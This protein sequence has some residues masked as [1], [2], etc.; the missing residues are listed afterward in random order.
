MIFLNFGRYASK[1]SKICF[2]FTELGDQDASAGL[3]DN[4]KKLTLQGYRVALDGYGNGSLN[5]RRISELSVNT[6]RLD[7]SLID[8]MELPGGE[9]V[10]RGMIGM[11]QSIPLTVVVPGVDDEKTRDRLLDMGCDLM[12]G[13]LF[14]M[15]TSEHRDF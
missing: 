5:I 4:I 2:A 15:E 10:L 8:E 11:L 12:M 1:S 3:L 7:Q 9:A 13:K 14:V 6:V